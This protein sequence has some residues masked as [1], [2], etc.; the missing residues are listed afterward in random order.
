MS[1]IK[2]LKSKL[3]ALD[4]HFIEGGADDYEAVAKVLNC[5]VQ[6]E[7]TINAYI[8]RLQAKFPDRYG[9]DSKEEEEEEEESSEEDREEGVEDLNDSEEEEAAPVFQ[10]EVQSLPKKESTPK[11]ILLDDGAF[12]L[13]ELEVVTDSERST[14][15]K[16]KPIRDLVDIIV[17]GKRVSVD[18][19]ELKG[20]NTHQTYRDYDIAAGEILKV[21]LIA[22]GD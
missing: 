1:E 22:K 16:R 5:E 10:R 4:T 3:E 11:Q 9:S 15:L 20:M 14:V 21:A 6:D 8:A 13:I 2:I 17:R 7:A 12:D 19:I 18:I